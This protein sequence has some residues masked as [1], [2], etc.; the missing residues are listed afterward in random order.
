MTEYT[1]TRSWEEDI[2][3]S[4]FPKK[5]CPKCFELKYEFVDTGLCLD[6]AMEKEVENGK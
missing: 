3:I 6:C 2:V 1:E 4:G 5:V